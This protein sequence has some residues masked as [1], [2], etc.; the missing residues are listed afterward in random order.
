MMK[1]VYPKEKV[2]RWKHH[3]IELL[4][5]DISF[6]REV[7][8]SNE[9]KKLNEV[10]NVNYNANFRLQIPGSDNISAIFFLRIYHQICKEECIPKSLNEM[11]NINVN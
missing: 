10:T 6:W 2:K 7:N 5:Q 11:I 8:T 3:F 9:S 1:Y 4:N